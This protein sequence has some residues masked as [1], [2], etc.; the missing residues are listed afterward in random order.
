M[1]SLIGADTQAKIKPCCIWASD[2]TKFLLKRTSPSSKLHTQVPH[3]PLQQECG[4]STPALSN[5]SSKGICLFHWIC[6]VLPFNV[7]VTF[8]LSDCSSWASASLVSS[9]GFIL[10][11]FILFCL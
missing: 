10:F 9:F 11:C 5:A 7:N 2:R 4:A 3:V 6:F 8:T 1:L